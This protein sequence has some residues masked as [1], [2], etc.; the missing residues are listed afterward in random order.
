MEEDLLTKQQVQWLSILNNSQPPNLGIMICP[1]CNHENEDGAL[2]C[3]HCGSSMNPVPEKESNT[4]SSLILS[5]IIAVA[6]MS[7]ISTMYTK[8]VDNWYESGPKMVYIGIQII[9]NIVMT[10]LMP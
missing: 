3:R 10:Q 2:F 1:K 6:I 7:I 5:W 8:L 9:Y 4:S